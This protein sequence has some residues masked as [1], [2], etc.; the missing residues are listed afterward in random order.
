MAGGR[1]EVIGG[2]PIRRARELVG[3]SGRE[4]GGRPSG[5]GG[6]GLGGEEKGIHRGAEERSF[7]GE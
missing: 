5:G 2:G 6:G 7:L 4:E 1:A 3:V